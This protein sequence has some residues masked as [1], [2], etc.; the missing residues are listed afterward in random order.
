MESFFWEKL[1]KNQGEKDYRF[2]PHLLF[3]RRN[4]GSALRFLQNPF[5]TL[6]KGGTNSETLKQ[7]FVCLFLGLFAHACLHL[8][9]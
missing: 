7:L 2:C 6:G 5:G 1:L 8:H 9:G 3:E 4:E